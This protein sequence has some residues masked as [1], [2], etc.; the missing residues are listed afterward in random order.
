MTTNNKTGAKRETTEWM[1]IDLNNLPSE[2]L[3]CEWKHPE[4][5]IITGNII[6]YSGERPDYKES[7]WIFPEGGDQA[8]IWLNE[9]THY[10]KFLS[11]AKVDRPE[12]K[13]AEEISQNIVN[14]TK[15]G[16]TVSAIFYGKQQIN[17][18]ASLQTAAIEEERDRYKKALERIVDLSHDKRT[19]WADIAHEALNK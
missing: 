2:L 9:F 14:I 17:H 13:T 8:D 1:P 5:G 16:G 6:T 10:R 12:A 18:F 15:K 19:Q 11:K 4:Y 3:I 7:K